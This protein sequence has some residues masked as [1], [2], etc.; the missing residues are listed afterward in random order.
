MTTRGTKSTIGDLELVPVDLAHAEVL[1]ALHGESFETPWSAQAFISLLSQPTVGGW[2]V[3][4]HE[5]TGFI[6]IQTAGGESEILTVVVAP[7]HRRSGIARQLITQAI[8]REQTNGSHLLHLEVAEDNAAA[9]A[10]YESLGFA[11]SGRRPGYYARTEGAVD[12]VLMTKPL[13]AAIT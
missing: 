2:I 7:S 5:P 11:P 9:I 12:A 1:A 13:G 3:G 4:Q 10:L 8:T 6:L